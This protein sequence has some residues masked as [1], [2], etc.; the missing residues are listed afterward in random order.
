MATF[1]EKLTKAVEK[2]QAKAEKNQEKAMDKLLENENFVE[3]QRSIIAKEKELEKLNEIVH[4]LNSIKPYIAKDGRKFSVNVFPIAVFGTGAAQVLGIVAGSRGAFIDEK[5][6]EYSAITGISSIELQEALVAM[7]SPAYYKDGEVCQ[8]VV[9]DY[10]KL[11]EILEGIY[12]KLGLHE[13]KVS[14][15]TKDKFDLW[16]ATAEARAIRQLNEHMELQKLHAGS[17]DF[18][19]EEV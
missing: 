15:I 12:L 3:V 6:L 8:A 13:F 1:N 16:Y 7:G 10:N 4:Q 17:G 11:V 19:L 18:V 2:A 5:L 9:G 14:D